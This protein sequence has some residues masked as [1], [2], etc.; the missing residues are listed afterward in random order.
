[1]KFLKESKYLYA[2]LSAISF[3]A[4]TSL[5]KLAML[6]INSQTIVTIRFS[7]LIV[8]I[9]LFT[10]LFKNLGY[11]KVKRKD[12]PL[13][14]GTGILLSMETLLFWYGLSS[15]NII[16]FLAIFWTFPLFD[17]LIDIGTGKVKN[18]LYA[19]IIVLIGAIGVYLGM[20]GL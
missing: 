11:L 5:G 7:L 9:L 1:M 2:I 20:G 13:M 19:F 15:A 16:P 17:L 4:F 18:K 3:G 8:S 10:L 14:A 12:I 6:E